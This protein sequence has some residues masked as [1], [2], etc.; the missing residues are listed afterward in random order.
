M[1]HLERET[2]DGRWIAL[3]GTQHKYDPENKTKRGRNAHGIMEDLGSQVR[4]IAD[5]GGDI[6]SKSRLK[7][8]SVDDDRWQSGVATY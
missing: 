8:R 5:S 3:P 1:P 4:E 2:I 6:C 7:R